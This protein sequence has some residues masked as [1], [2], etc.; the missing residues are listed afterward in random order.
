MTS[1][2]D[3]KS[4]KRTL[5]SKNLK[6]F[7]A[8]DREENKLYDCQVGRDVKAMSRQC[9]KV[10]RVEITLEL[11]TKAHEDFTI[12]EKA[13]TRVLSWLKAPTRAFTKIVISS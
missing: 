6:P 5:K 9:L 10:P 12:M 2:Q 8:A 3:K 13:P 11:Q 7:K 4:K 1:I